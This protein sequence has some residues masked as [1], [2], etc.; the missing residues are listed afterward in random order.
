MNYGYIPVPRG[1]TVKTA[2]PA[3]KPGPLARLASSLRRRKVL[4]AYATADECRA[5]HPGCEPWRVP[6]EVTK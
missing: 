3:E 4:P 5:R 2:Q 1:R 6:L